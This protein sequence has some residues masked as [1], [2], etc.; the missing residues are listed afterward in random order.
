M[1]DCIQKSWKD[2]KLLYHNMWLCVKFI[3]SEDNS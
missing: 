3:D 1:S 2:I